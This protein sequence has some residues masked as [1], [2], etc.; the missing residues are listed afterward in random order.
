MR[1]IIPSCLLL[2]ISLTT[3]AQTSLFDLWQ[4]AS[5]HV[6]IYSYGLKPVKKDPCFRPD[7]KQKRG[8]KLEISS[9]TIGLLKKML[10]DVESEGFQF[11][12]QNDTLLFYVSFCSWWAP[13]DLVVK[14]S[15]G[16]SH[17][18]QP[19]KEESFKIDSVML[20]EDFFISSILYYGDNSAFT[21]FFRRYVILFPN[22]DGRYTLVFRIILK[23][24]KIM[25]PSEVWKI[26]ADV[27]MWEG[28]YLTEE[29]IIFLKKLSRYYNKSDLNRLENFSRT[30]LLQ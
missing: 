6:N 28:N 7:W 23:D 26:I 11:N 17:Y 1:K 4:E 3:Y 5:E 24:G 10:E 29:D 2:G 22:S 18:Y 27:Y 16:I 19:P 13:C 21:D 30:I 12:P 25:T 20:A 14:T 9:P 8:A 15:A